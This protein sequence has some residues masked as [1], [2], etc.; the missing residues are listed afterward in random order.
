MSFKAIVLVSSSRYE[1]TIFPGTTPRIIRGLFFVTRRF[2]FS[3]TSSSLLLYVVMFIPIDKLLAAW[4]LKERVYVYL[5]YSEGIIFSLNSI[6][7]TLSCT[8]SNNS[9]I[10]CSVAEPSITIVVFPICYCTA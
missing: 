3:D 9:C 4:P 2:S 8:F 1:C 6:L 10:S 7:F 5:L